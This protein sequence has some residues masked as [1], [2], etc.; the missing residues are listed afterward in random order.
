MKQEELPHHQVA[1]LAGCEVTRSELGGTII[2]CPDHD[3]VVAACYAMA[4]REP[5]PLTRKLAR[6]LTIAG[7]GPVR[8]ERTA[9]LIQRWIQLHIQFAEEHPETFQAPDVTLERRYGDCDDHCILALS[10]ARLLRVQ[11]RIVPFARGKGWSHVAMQYWAH[12]DWRWG[13]TTLGAGFGEE[14]RAAK[15]RLGKAARSDV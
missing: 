5:G 13:E 6:E 2:T 8:E 4:L 3:A 12:G 7:R 15:K 14:P 9:R 10:L 1:G 11:A